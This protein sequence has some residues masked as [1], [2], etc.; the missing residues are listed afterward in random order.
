MSDKT[1]TPDI[2]TSTI[3]IYCC[4][5]CNRFLKDNEILETINGDLLCERCN[6]KLVFKDN[7]VD[8]LNEIKEDIEHMK[9]EIVKIEGDGY[10]N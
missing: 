7:L 6:M 1:T 3:E 9:Q 4:S 10:G 5:N 8:V 2:K